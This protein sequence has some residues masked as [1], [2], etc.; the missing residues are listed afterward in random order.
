MLFQILVGLIIVQGN[1]IECGQGW[2]GE[3]TFKLGKVMREIS[4]KGAFELISK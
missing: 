1:V 4:V 3:G 2:E